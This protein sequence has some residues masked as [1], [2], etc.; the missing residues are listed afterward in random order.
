M[1]ARIFYSRITR[2][3]SQEIAPCGLESEPSQRRS[4][5]GQH[6][7]I[8]RRC[9]LDLLFGEGDRRKL[10]DFEFNQPLSIE[11]GSGN[12]EYFAGESKYVR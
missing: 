9:S 2:T 6:L 11:S 3:S 1:C 5:I 4:Q 7:C 10:L 12:T 8:C